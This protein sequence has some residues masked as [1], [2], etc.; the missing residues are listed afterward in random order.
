MYTPPNGA[1]RRKNL[2][3]HDNKGIFHYLLI[4]SELIAATQKRGQKAALVQKIAFLLL[5]VRKVLYSPYHLRGVG[6]LVVIPR[7]DLNL[8][9][10]V[11]HGSD[12]RLGSV[13]QRA[14]GDADDVGGNELFLGVA[15]GLV[16]S[17]LHSRIDLLLGHIAL[18]DSYENC[19]GA[20]GG[21]YSLRR[22]DELSV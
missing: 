14:V 21:G 4:K 2:N 13:E 8:R 1:I 9:E 18:Y 3:F 20:G 16:R 19:R 5:Y 15:E 12:H 10:T 17:R 6:V 11:I 7:N 22:A